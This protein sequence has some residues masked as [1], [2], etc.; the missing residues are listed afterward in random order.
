MH[1]ILVVH[2]YIRFDRKMMECNF[3]SVTFS[4]HSVHDCNNVKNF[5]KRAKKLSP[6]HHSRLQYAWHDADQSALWLIHVYL[7]TGWFGIRSLAQDG[8][9]A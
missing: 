7:Y 2:V 5:E 1:V 8:L 3:H 4:Y 9:L 6:A